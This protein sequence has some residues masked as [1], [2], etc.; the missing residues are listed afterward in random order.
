[1]FYDFR[2]YYAEINLDNFRHNF[3]EVKRLAK[4]KKT[5]GVIKADGYGHGAVELARVLDEE[6]ADYFAVAVVTEAIEL[7]KNGY[8]KPILILGFTPPTFAKEIVEYD[9]TQTVFSYEL[10][11]AISAEAKKQEKTAKIHIKLD[12]G[13]GRVGFIANDDAVNEILRIAKLDNIYLEGIF[14]H[15][16]SADELDKSFTKKQIEKYVYVVDKL[17]EKGIEFE[18]KHVS[19]SAAIIDLPEAYY[20]A[21]R[22]GIMLYGYYPSDEVNKERL[23]LKPVMTLKANIVNIKEVSEDTPISYGRKFYTNRKSKIAT[24]PFGYA[25]GFTRLLFGKAFVIINGK[26]APIVGRICM[27]QCM[28]DVTDCGDVKVGDEV[29]VMGQ[30]DGIRNNA[31]DIAKMLGT[32]SYEVLCMVSKRVPRV[33]TENGEI[34][35]V[36]NYV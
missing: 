18:I 20:D 29:I 11:E 33:Y 28:V 12:T 21:V 36:K 30:K 9:I 14:T 23:I 5:F 17:K 2:P 16:A 34:I 22:P 8:K 10:A 13:M 25:D 4:G 24:L 3:R 27:D 7:R 6:G 31:D 1:M 15:F 26:A 35:K 32:I 19:N